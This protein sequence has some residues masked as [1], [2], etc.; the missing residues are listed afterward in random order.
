MTTDTV[1]DNTLTNASLSVG[2]IFGTTS[3]TIDAVPMAGSSNL[4]TDH[5]WY[6]VTLTAGQEYVFGAAVT[7][8]LSADYLGNAAID[9]YDASG[10]LIS[11]TFDDSVAPTFTYRPTI[12]GRCR[13]WRRRLI[14]SIH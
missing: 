5:D 2:E 4:S 14:Y 6:K 8:G 13:D 11:G 10:A 9:L 7:S 1:L 3:G 12:S